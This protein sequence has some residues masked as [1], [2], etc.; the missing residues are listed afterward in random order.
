MMI[1]DKKYGESLI[2]KMLPIIDQDKRFQE[3]MNFYHKIIIEAFALPID[4]NR[5]TGKKP[6][7]L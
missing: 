5:I 4:P 6:E 2:I 3:V 7:G 1:E